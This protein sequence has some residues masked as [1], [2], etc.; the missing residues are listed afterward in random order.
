[1]GGELSACRSGGENSWSA[2]Q[3][4]PAVCKALWTSHDMQN[5]NAKF[6]LHNCYFKNDKLINI[7]LNVLSYSF[8]M[9]FSEP[10]QDSTKGHCYS[11]DFWFNQPPRKSSQQTSQTHQSS[12]RILSLCFRCSHK[13][14]YSI[15]VY[16]FESPTFLL[17]NLIYI[18]ITSFCTAKYHIL[19]C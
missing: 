6:V 5:C 4:L 1:M 8:N 16:S 7:T 11:H 12:G 14:S 13:H 17:F 10:L 9:C 15:I 19:H 18:I 2:E 3:A